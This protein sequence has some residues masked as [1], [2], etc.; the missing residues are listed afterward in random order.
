MAEISFLWLEDP[1]PT[2]L[3]TDFAVRKANGS[4]IFHLWQAPKLPAAVHRIR[5]LW[6]AEDESGSVALEAETNVHWQSSSKETDDLKYIESISMAK[7]E[8]FCFCKRF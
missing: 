5:A 2:S 1:E 8:F 3:S 7:R 4:L 6:D